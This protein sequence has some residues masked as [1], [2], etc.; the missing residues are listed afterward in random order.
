MEVI[1]LSW[2]QLALAASLVLA[3]AACIHLARLGLGGNLLIAAAR[4]VIQLTLIGLVL[5]TLFSVGSLLWVALMGLAMLLLAG[6]EVMARQKYRLQGGW[7]FAIGTLAM[8]ISAF[9]VTVL[10]LTAVIG[11]QPWYTPQYAIPLLGMLLGNTMTGVALALDRLTETV[12]RQRHAIES[13][14]MLGQTWSEASGDIRRE[15]MRSGLM[16]IINAMAAAG[17]VSLPGMMTG[18]I[19]AGTPPALAVK[20]QI[21]IMF[22]IAAGTGFGTFMAVSAA[23]RRL[24]DRRERLRL[25]RLTADGRG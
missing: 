7:S 9:S 19:L 3:L 13:R 17:I 2:W 1:Q 14:L 21:L 4:T 5:E 10:T 8:S 20:Y 25:D 6:R 24:F 16:P 12:W 18:Q 22:V 11:P 23:S 15:A